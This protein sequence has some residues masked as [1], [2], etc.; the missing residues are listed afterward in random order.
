MNTTPDNQNTE[1][2][3]IMEFPCVFPLK[4]M[5]YNRDNF[6]DQ[7][8]NLVQGFVSEPIESKHVETRPS[9]TEK[10]MAVTITF[11]AE[12]KAQLDS[13]YHAMTD[14]ELVTMAL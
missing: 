13:I 4:V 11:T 9:R 8:Q 14:H 2:T 12:S 1:T 7:M 6:V 5:G 3:E 10:F